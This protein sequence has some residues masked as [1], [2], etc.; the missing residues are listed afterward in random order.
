MNDLAV[1][2]YDLNPPAT[3][4]LR[5]VLDGLLQSP[6]RISPKFFYDHRGSQLF[7]A[8]TET[9][10]YYPFRTE[11]S[12]LEQHGE[13][14]AALLGS[15]CL[16]VEL[17]SGSSRKIRL[18][19]DALRPA[20]YMPVDISRDFL[21]EAASELA[22]DYP[23]LEVHATCADYS[24]GLELPWS[25]QG[26]PRA[27]F[28][29]GSSIGNFE[30]A[31]AK[32]LLRHVA[33]A[34]GRGGYLLIGVDL[35]KDQAVLNRAY[36]DAAGYT[37]AFNRNLLEHLNRE[38]GTDFNLHGFRHCAYYNT[39]AERVEMYLVSR[40]IQQVSIGGKRISFRR[41]DTIHTENSYKYTHDGFAALAVAAGFQPVKAWTDER[42]YFSVHC[43]RV[44]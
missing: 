37:A 30:P 33:Q 11:L 31:Q 36:N 20:A 1:R 18:L 26:V 14:M 12:L 32:Q 24:R 43:L 10:E 3:D 19:L 42:Q 38:I 21:L 22:A 39:T 41:G 16:L 2:F 13:E 4:M 6:R 28:F 5:E 44:V 15:D 9:P 34:L 35:Q 29:P 17:G 23:G 40:A 27:A 8:I 7:E 25:P